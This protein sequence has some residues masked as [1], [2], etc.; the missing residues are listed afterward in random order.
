[1]KA[2]RPRY[3]SFAMGNLTSDRDYL[4]NTVIRCYDIRVIPMT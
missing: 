2:A 3:D 1:M 4:G